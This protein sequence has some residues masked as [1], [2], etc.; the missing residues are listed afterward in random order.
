M[1][2]SRSPYRV[3]IVGAGNI[4]RM[5]IDGMSRHAD[6]MK[7]VALCDL[8]TKMAQKRAADYGIEHTYNDL[9]EM[10]GQANL[11]V[12]VVCTPTH[13][14]KQVVIPLINANIPIFCEKPFA[15]TYA[16]AKDIETAVRD[17][18][19][20]F[21]LNQNLRRTFS[22]S[23]ARKII[24]AGS[25]GRPL[26]LMHTVAVLRRDKGWR[27]ERKRYVMS[28]MSI[29]W[30]DGYRYL[31]QDEPDEVYCRS[32]NSPA[33]AGGDDT[34]V[35]LILHFRKGTVVTLSESFSSLT[36]PQNCSLDCESGGLEL[37]YQSVVEFGPEGQT[38]EHQ[39]PFTKPEAT[40]WLL[41]D[42]MEGVENAR[43]PETSAADNLKSIRILEAA[44]RSI[45]ENR[46]VRIEE[47]Q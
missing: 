9:E 31:L 18:G 41:N 16:E 44:Y 2:N 13:V 37:G 5:H 10:I 12:A 11:D 1:N 21:A 24:E 45:E 29:H 7:V 47:V 35:S 46:A 19:S 30:F 22:F 33:T 14:R 6:R 23:V 26:H 27:L 42:L 38:A 43:E 20:A 36:K 17:S 8:D 3:G 25:L 28:V 34:A 15:E 39:N 4:S 40:Y 32:I